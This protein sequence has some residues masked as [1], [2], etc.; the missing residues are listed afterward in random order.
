MALLLS[1]ASYS[2][3]C[4]VGPGLVGRGHRV[5]VGAAGRPVHGSAGRFVRTGVPRA[6]RTS[7]RL[8]F[9]VQLLTRC[10]THSASPPASVSAPGRVTSP[11]FADS[12]GCRVRTG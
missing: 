12:A 7:L 5:V 6:L 2:R 9:G 11:G 8:R 4:L 3:V 1:S 10:L